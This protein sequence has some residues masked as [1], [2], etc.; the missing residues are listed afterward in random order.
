[1]TSTGNG[2]RPRVDPFGIVGDHD[3][4][5]RRRG[6]DLLPQQRAAAALDQV[7]RGIDFVGAVDREVE[8]VDLVERGQRNPAALRRRRGLLPMSARRSR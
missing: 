1:M 6:H 2:K 8:P 3:H 4:A 7:E 5:I